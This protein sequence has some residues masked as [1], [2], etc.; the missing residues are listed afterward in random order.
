MNAA[1]NVSQAASIVEILIARAT[2]QPDRTA[3]HF[4]GDGPAG[5]VRLTYGELLREAASL[6]TSLQLLHLKG[7]PV[8]LACKTNFFFVVG[9]Y[10][11]LMSGALAVPTAPPRRQALEQRIA[12]LV[13]H[14]G[15]SAALTDS[16]AMLAMN[17]NLTMID[18]REGRPDPDQAQPVLW[19]QDDFAGDTP[20]LIQYTS[21]TTG[22]PHGVLHSHRGL[23][24]ATAA[25]GASFGHDERS[26]LLITLPL[27]HELGLMYGVLHPLA[28]GLPAW[29]MTPAQFVQRPQ[30]WLHLIQRHRIT[31]AGGPN[32]MLDIIAR[33][34]DSTQLEGL[35]LS[36][37]HACFCTGEP[38]RAA[39]MARLM[40]LLQPFGLRPQALLPCY[41]L[42]EAGR[43]LTGAVTGKPPMLDMPAM[44][45]AVH[46]VVSCG[47][48]HDD[49]QVLVVDPV[50]R[51]VAADGE[52]GEIWLRCASAGL[53]YWN[54]PLLSE[55]VFGALLKNGDGPF[56]RSGDAAYMHDGELFVL[57]RLADRIRFSGC[58]H[59]P[60]DLELQVERSHEGLRPSCAAAFTVDGI[61]RSKLVVVCELKREMLRRRE[62]WPHI[63]LAIR[64]AI[65]RVHNIS[66]D[67]VVLLLP[68]ALP[69]TSSGK[70]RR[71][72]CRTSYLQGSLAVAQRFEPPPDG[73]SEPVEVNDH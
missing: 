58:E 44:A 9:L 72:H 48:A 6:A 53:A 5:D 56:I 19:A 31:T 73:E 34:P 59:A 32:F 10:A 30:R 54:E 40:E 67:D 49:A 62:K 39:T 41:S 37:L 57:G 36:S 65:R 24:A 18:I 52:I 4:I 13:S 61:E 64:S 23:L 8:L 42:S 21:G 2:S 27:F 38:V 51:C 60:H 12:Y 16:D 20:A 69:K 3:Y 68:G 22:E 17:V 50:S 28:W 45:G 71:N 7:Q 66:V 55:A 63:E 46:P 26:A 25:V 43:H 14:S 47:L 33:T 70:V 1:P 15:A 11:C 35:D 29:L